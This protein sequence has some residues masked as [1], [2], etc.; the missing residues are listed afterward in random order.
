MIWNFSENSGR[1]LDAE[2]IHKVEGATQEN[3]AIK[4]SKSTGQPAMHPKDNN[5]DTFMCRY[6]T[7]RIV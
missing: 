2:W 6:L 4:T 5:D 7:L 1:Q 3:A